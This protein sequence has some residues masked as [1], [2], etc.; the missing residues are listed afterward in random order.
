VLPPQLTAEGFVDLLAHARS[1]ASYPPDTELRPIATSAIDGELAVLRGV[2]PDTAL[3]LGVTPSTLDAV[4]RELGLLAGALGDRYP[5]THVTLASPRPLA[6][7]ELAHLLVSLSRHFAVAPDAWRAV[8]VEARDTSTGQLETLAALG[9]HALHTTARD[10]GVEM[11]IDRARAC[12]FSD[13]DVDVADGHLRDDDFATVLDAV[14]AASPDRVTLRDVSGPDSYARATRLLLA[15]DRL[16]HAGYVHLGRAQF[17]RPHARLARLP[18]VALAVGLGARSSTPRMTWVDHDDPGAWHRAIAEHRLPV[19]RGV[20]L[21]RD[22]RIRA[23]LI[24]RLMRDGEVDLDQLGRELELD[25]RS[26]FAAEL[27]ALDEVAALAT[28]DD[29]RVVRTTPVGR[30][31]VP[32]VCRVFD[33]YHQELP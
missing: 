26:Y 23:A 5:L 11:L 31:L 21:D 13:L 12:G 30:L 24:D 16:V 29:G 27:D 7:I 15:V 10:G 18:D 22:D 6:P 20:V 3:R 32:N 33:R 25:A 14:V 28:L 1:Y 2:R 8:E 17:A 9:F 19:A 4:A